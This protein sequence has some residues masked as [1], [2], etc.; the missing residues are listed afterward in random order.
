MGG[1]FFFLEKKWNEPKIDWNLQ[2]HLKKSLNYFFLT[3]VIPPQMAVF[4]VCGTDSK[5][6]LTA[7]LWAASS[8]Y[9]PPYRMGSTVIKI[10]PFLGV[11]LHLKS[12]GIFFFPF[13]LGK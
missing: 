5:G 2:A 1:F 12:L 9:R 6:I 8:I 10:T 13:P 3:N 11:K 7:T 4:V